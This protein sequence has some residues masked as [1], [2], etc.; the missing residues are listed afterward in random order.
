L[1]G[2]ATFA[3]SIRSLRKRGRHVQVGLLTEWDDIPSSLLGRL[4]AWELEI[5]GSHGLPAHAYS[6]LVELI[7]N[8]KLDPMRFVDRQPTLDEA[9]LALASMDNY[10]GC[11]ITVFTPFS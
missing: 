10:L 2:A 9:P 8:G 6:G 4:I 5:A 11:G 7:Q 3:N 1:G